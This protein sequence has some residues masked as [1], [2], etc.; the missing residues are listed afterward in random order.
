MPKL[1]QNYIVIWYHTYLLR[2]GMYHTEATISQ[3]F[4]FPNLSEEIWTHIEFCKTSQKKK[5]NKRLVVY[6][7]SKQRLYLG[8][9]Y[10]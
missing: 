1:F 2:P 4:Y 6:P 7:K 9:D 8:A 10:L 3:N 5:Q